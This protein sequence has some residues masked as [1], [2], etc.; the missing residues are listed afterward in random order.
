MSE[1][2]YPIYSDDERPEGDVAAEPEDEVNDDEH[3]EVL[4]DDPEEDG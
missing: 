3:T 2:D 4:P 1:P